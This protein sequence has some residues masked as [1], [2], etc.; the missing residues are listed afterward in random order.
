[1][2][3]R[4]TT[5]VKGTFCRTTE[6]KLHEAD[7]AKLKQWLQAL[8]KTT[9]DVDAI[10]K[11]FGVL[12]PNGQKHYDEFFKNGSGCFFPE[13]EPKLKSD[14]VRAAFIQAL[15][16]SIYEVRPGKDSTLPNGKERSVRRPIFFYW[17]AGGPAFEAYVAD[18]AGPTGDADPASQVHL[19]LLTPDPT[20]TLIPPADP[21]KVRDEPIWVIASPG[22]VAAIRDRGPYTYEP[23]EPLPGGLDAEC[24]LTKSY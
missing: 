18:A 21:Q 2:P 22:R 13:L 24:Q 23:P 4:L 5:V 9:D 14:V 11:L 17:I 19:L 3:G 7:I 12:D 8:E 1:M 6:R 20:P 10:G 16:L 15:R